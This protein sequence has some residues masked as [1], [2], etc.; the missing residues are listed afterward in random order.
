MADAGTQMQTEIEVVA[1]TQRKLRVEVP[2]DRVAKAFTRIY[3]EFGRSAK[4]R[5]FR[6]GKV[7]RHVLRGLYGAE[8]QAQALSEIVETALAEAV[9]E[10]GLDPVSE[11]RLETGDLNDAQPFAFSAVLEVKPDIVLKNYR[12]IALE[13][14]RVDVGDEEVQRALESLRDRGAQLEPVEERDRVEDG[15][16]VFVDFEGTVEGEPFPGGKA[17]SFPVEIGAGTALPEFE[18]GLVG[19][20]REVAG[21]IAVPFPE[22]SREPRLSGKLA[23]FTVTVRDIRRKVV[24]PL[25]DDFARD[26]GECD[27]LDELRDKARSQLQRE[28]EAFQNTRLHDRIV[29]H[30]L[31]EHDVDA[32]PSMVE[33]ELSYL[34]RRAA[35]QRETEAPDAPQPTTDELREELTPQAQRRVKASLLVG[36]I[37]DAEAITASEDELDARIDAMARASGD[38]AASVREQ[39]RQDWARAGLRSQLVSEKTLDFLLEQADV[40]L[41]EPEENG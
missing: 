8:I 11:P 40:T 1:P 37:A 35:T 30:L 12:A 2:A 22:D 17:E 27:S 25:D 28:V 24:P 21:T 13:R 23:E 31:E 14:P 7:P 32:P 3:R 15:D 6:A 39:Y 10:Q 36:K 5:G 41:V 20:E 4:V 19:M 38:R 16:Y 33:R 18:R 9:G 26:Y 34:M 29:E